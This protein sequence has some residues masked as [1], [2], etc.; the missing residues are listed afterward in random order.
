FRMA[1]SRDLIEFLSPALTPV[2]S[3]FGITRGDTYLLTLAPMAVLSTTEAGKQVGRALTKTP[4]VKLINNR[5][6]I[7]GA[8]AAKVYPI[9]KLPV[10]L[11]QKY[12][13]SVPFTGTGH[14][15]FSRYAVK[16]VE[17]NMTGNQYLDRKQANK[18]SG[19]Q[20]TPKGY[21]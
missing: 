12:P 20:K 11:R 1:L 5:M 19:Y 15:D 17:I 9:E 3:G 6:P 4:R 2:E 7:N 18:I 10:E 21:T 8:Y 13:H 16:K 14:P